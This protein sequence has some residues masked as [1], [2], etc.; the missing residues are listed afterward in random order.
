MPKLFFVLE[1]FHTVGILK[2]TSFQPVCRAF[3]AIS[4]FLIWVRTTLKGWKLG[5]KDPHLSRQMNGSILKWT[6][7]RKSWWFNLNSLFK[8]F[9]LN[10]LFFHLK[11]ISFIF[12]YKKTHNKN[13]PILYKDEV[14]YL[15][16]FLYQ[17]LK[18]IKRKQFTFIQLFSYY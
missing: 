2:K 10:S 9:N 7:T 17:I 18:S 16:G 14:S 5:E 13:V 6:A 11:I 3:D 1:M 15:F 4:S 8:W 12:L